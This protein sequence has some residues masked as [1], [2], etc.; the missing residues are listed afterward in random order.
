LII[1]LVDFFSD[2]TLTLAEKLP[3]SKHRAG[4][5]TTAQTALPVHVANRNQFAM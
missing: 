5:A 1:L 2:P 3:G 4:I